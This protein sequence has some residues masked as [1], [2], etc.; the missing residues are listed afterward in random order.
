MIENYVRF[1]HAEKDLRSV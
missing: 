1:N